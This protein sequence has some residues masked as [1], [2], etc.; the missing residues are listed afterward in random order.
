MR[1]FDDFLAE[2]RVTNDLLDLGSSCKDPNVFAAMLAFHEE[3]EALICSPDGSYSLTGNLL[4]T[5]KKVFNAIGS[6]AL[7]TLS[8]QKKIEDAVSNPLKPKLVQMPASHLSKKWDSLEELP[9]P[10]FYTEETGRYVTAGVICVTDP[11]TGSRNLSFARLKVLNANK[12]LL[13]VSPNHHL[14]MIAEKCAKEAIPM[15]YSLVLGVDPA[16]SIAACLYLGFGVDEMEA[17]GA[18]L[19]APISVFEDPLTGAFVPSD[20]QVVISGEIEPGA[21]EIEGRV[22]EYH[23]RYHEYGPGL[24]TKIL[25]IQSVNKPIVPI[26]VPGFHSEHLLIGAVSIAAGLASVLKKVEPAI[27]EVAVPYTGN[28]RTKAVISCSSIP[29]SRARHLIMAAWSAVPLIKEVVIVDEIVDP[30]N[31]DAVEWARVNHARPGRDLFM[32]EGSRGDRSDPLAKN[33]VI[34]KIGFHAQAKDEDR[35]EGWT[36]AMLD[37]ETAS[38]ALTLLK[39]L[40]IEPRENRVNQGLRHNRY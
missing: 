9:F 28:G 20:C 8:A 40:D 33:S 19:H 31:S 17:A 38:Q 23:G 5:F 22:S 27:K 25:G 12:G 34:D 13:G 21:K 30:W 7:D 24:V 15:K 14:G 32:V 6:D 2:L 16:V 26:I 10:H 37:S 36:W 1:G 4:N 35:D 29:T 3:G 11:I 39:D 18:L